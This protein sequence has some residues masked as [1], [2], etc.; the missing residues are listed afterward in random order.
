LGF[1]ERK[2]INYFTVKESVFPFV[3]FS[4]IDPVL[5]PEMKSTG[6]VMGIDDSWGKAFYKAQIAAGNALPTEGKYL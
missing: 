2:E 6:E 3:K 1:T 4:N 5:G